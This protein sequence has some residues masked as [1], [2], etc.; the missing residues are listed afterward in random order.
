M[1]QKLLHI[2]IHICES[3]SFSKTAI[4]MHISPSALSRQVQKLEVD[5]GQALFVRDNRS[6]E[7]TDAGKKLLP[8]AIHMLSEWHRLKTNL[9]NEDKLLTGELHIFCSVTASYSHLP[10]LL[11]NFRIHYPQI[12]IKLSTG[13]PAQSIGMIL[14]DRADI[15]ISAKP[16]VLPSKLTFKTID[17]ITLSIIIPSG[18]SNFANELH[19]SPVNWDKI[20][21]I[22]PEEGT[23]RERVNTWFKNRKVKPTIYAQVSG[24]EAIVSMVALGCGV[25]IAPDVVISNSPVKDKVTRVEAINIKGFDLGVCCKQSQLQNPLVNAFWNLVES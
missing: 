12:E 13:D 20:P 19:Q 8:V 4:A 11:S 23:A 14:Q 18:I 2:F 17:H 10:E 22:V 21:F 24:H 9:S 15:A 25:G 1:N 5:I 16:N 6:V 3:K 7:L